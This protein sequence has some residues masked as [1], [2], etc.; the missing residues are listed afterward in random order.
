[1]FLAIVLCVALGYA[2]TA[3]AASVSI[4]IDLGVCRIDPA[5]QNGQTRVPAHAPLFYLEGHKLSFHSFDD[6]FEIELWQNGR[7]L[8][9]QTVEAGM[10]CVKLP[11]VLKGTFSLI[12][13]FESI[14]YIGNIE[15]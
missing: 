6:D 4:P 11:A 9:S 10:D 14:A 8:H 12:I 3:Q 13:K 15:L 1:M 2:S 5:K 7:L